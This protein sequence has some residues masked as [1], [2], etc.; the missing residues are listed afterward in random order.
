MQNHISHDVRFWIATPFVGLTCL[1]SI[2]ALNA[3][4]MFWGGTHYAPLGTKLGIWFVI[5]AGTAAT[6]IVRKSPL[7]ALLLAALQLALVALA[8]VR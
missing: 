3:K 8:S 7:V 5:L 1:V 2:L 4:L 6:A